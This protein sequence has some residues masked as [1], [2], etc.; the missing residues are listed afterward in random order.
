M[1]TTL[2]FTILF[3]CIIS[4]GNAQIL[5]DKKNTYKELNCY[6][7]RIDADS[8]NYEDKFIKFTLLPISCWIWKIR[9]ENQTKQNMTIIWNEAL[10]IVNQ[11]SAGF[12]F[13]SR[14]LDYFT[15]PDYEETLASNSYIE[16]NC[17]NTILKGRFIYD[18][19]KIKKTGLDTHIRLVF[20]IKIN[21]EIKIYDFKYKVYLINQEKQK[22]ALEKRMKKMLKKKINNPD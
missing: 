11:Q 5:K 21:G 6:I 9:I 15:T 1:K 7:E 17:A 2:I 13:Y 20:P 3:T 16:Y 19:G 4:S 14:N 8:F 18:S 22:K 10:F 12:L